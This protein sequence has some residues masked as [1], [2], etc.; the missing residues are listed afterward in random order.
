MEH[1][2]AFSSKPLSNGNAIPHPIS[3]FVNIRPKDTFKRLNRT[4]DMGE[5]IGI[6]SVWSSIELQKFYQIKLHC[7]AKKQTCCTQRH[8]GQ[9][10]RTT[11]CRNKTNGEHKEN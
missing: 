1:A 6:M 5:S 3:N 11:L 7:K 10:E 2:I 4:P 9:T 8:A